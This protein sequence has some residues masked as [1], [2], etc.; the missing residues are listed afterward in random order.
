MLACWTTLVLHSVSVSDKV[1]QASHVV[2]P[3]FSE[4]YRETFYM[5]CSHVYYFPYGFE[6][7]E[8]GCYVSCT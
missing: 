3:M 8:T 5:L 1:E 4:R 2:F 7:L 6:R